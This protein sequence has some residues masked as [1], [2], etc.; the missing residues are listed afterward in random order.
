[1]LYCRLLV[2]NTTYYSPFF[3]L[4]RRNLLQQPKPTPFTYRK[5][6]S[7][8]YGEPDWAN[9]SASTPA[10][11]SDAAATTSW[12]AGED[13]SGTGANVNVGGANKAT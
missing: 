7:G 4:L 6:M 5:I 2:T 10:A 9:P 1:M 8:A 11:S 12:S 3:P 13:F